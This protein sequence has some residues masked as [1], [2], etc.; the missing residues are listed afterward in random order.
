MGVGGWFVEGQECFVEDWMDLLPCSGESE[1]IHCESF[2]SEDFKG[3]ISFVSQLAGSCHGNVGSFQPNFVS[4]FVITSLHLLFA[5]KCLHR[6]SCLGQ[7]SL[8][9]NSGLGEVVDKVLGHL[10]F[11]FM[12][13]FESFIG[14]SSV[15]EEEW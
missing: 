15:V 5:V 6:F 2:L 7:C 1:V 9:L 4:F 8:C 13:G 12:M 10:A 14:V 3:S 11:D